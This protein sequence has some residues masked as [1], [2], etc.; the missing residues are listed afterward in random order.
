MEFEEFAPL[1]FHSTLFSSLP[2]IL[3]AIHSSYTAAARWRPQVH[4]ETISFC[5]Q[6]FHRCKFVIT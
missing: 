1:L 3:N 6:P 5:A 2:F 4:L